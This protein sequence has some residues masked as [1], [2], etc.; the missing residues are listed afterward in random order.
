MIQEAFSRRTLL[1]IGSTLA[2]GDLAGWR[3]STRPQNSGQRSATTRPIIPG[4]KMRY[5]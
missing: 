1:Q 2:A 5:C 4:R 3:A